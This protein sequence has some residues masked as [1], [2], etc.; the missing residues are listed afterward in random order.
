[1][2]ALTEGMVPAPETAH[3]IRGVIDVALAVREAQQE[4]VILFNYSS[5][6]LL[7]MTAYDD[8]LHSRLPAD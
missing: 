6:R 3:A 7:D 4:T 8:H 2:F 1:M 5:Y